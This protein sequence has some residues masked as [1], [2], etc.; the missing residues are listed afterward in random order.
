M[1]S[2]CIIVCC[3]SMTIYCR[4]PISEE[5]RNKKHYTRQLR[6]QSVLRFSREDKGEAHVNCSLF[7]YF[8]QGKATVASSFSNIR[9]V[10]LRNNCH[11]T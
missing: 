2:L 4:S 11:I 3:V 6:A 8:R 9:D 10:S 5:N 1:A 7:F